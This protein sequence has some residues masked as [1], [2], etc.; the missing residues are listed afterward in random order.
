[1]D[2]TTL[3][4]LEAALAATPDNHALRKVVLDGATALGDGAAIGRLLEGRSADELP[5]DVRRSAAAALTALGRTEDALGWLIGTSPELLVD[6]ARL[7]AALERVD[8]ARAAYSEAVAAN[9][10]L[11]DPAFYAS[12]APRERVVAREDGRPALR[13]LAAGGEASDRVDDVPE[14]L[15]Q[16]TFEDVGG[17]EPLKKRIR[18]QII[19]PLKKP[20]LFA[21]FRRKAGGG[22]LMYGPPGCGKTLLARA[23]AGETG[24]SFINVAI[25][26]VLDMWI[27]ESEQKLHALFERARGNTPS[28]L[29]F[30]EV[31]ALGGKRQH[32]RDHS[33][34]KLVSQFLTELDGFGNDN[35]GVLVLAATNVPWA[36]DPAFRR[37]GRF[38]RVVFVPPPDREARVRILEL[39]LKDRP[40][41]GVDAAAIAAKTA[42]YSGADLLHLVESA[43][44]LAIDESL[45]TGVEV[46]IGM[47]HVVEALDEVRPTTREWLTTARNY[48]RYANESGQYDDV[49]AFLDKHGRR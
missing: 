11:E 41:E 26:D 22:V 44:D 37:P 25:S 20:G 30:D 4:S 21:R 13:L 31:E 34:A 16:I 46:P 43:A 28:V 38:D 2:A 12:L 19:T 6:K 36:V 48:A 3:A 29:F 17:L 42:W 40:V 49:L 9:K 8:E 23:T 39:H 32:S 35:D 47:S 33:G 10:T 1:M 18:K 7:L 24:G 15:P 14:E 5:E 45:E 27:G